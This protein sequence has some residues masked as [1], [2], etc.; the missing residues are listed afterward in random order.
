[1]DP[2]ALQP[3]IRLRTTATYASV[4]C[5]SDKCRESF[6]S[7]L[8]SVVKPFIEIYYH[9]DRAY[10]RTEVRNTSEAKSKISTVVSDVGSVT[11]QWRLAF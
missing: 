6:L 7:K 1:M 5:A 11:G 3:I 4:N 9:D 10:G 2:T 8:I